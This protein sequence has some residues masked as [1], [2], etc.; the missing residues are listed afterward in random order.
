MNAGP[1]HEGHSDSRQSVVGRRTSGGCPGECG[2]AGAESALTRLAEDPR[3][4]LRI[5]GKTVLRLVEAAQPLQDAIALLR[6]KRQIGSTDAGQQQA[7]E[8]ADPVS[9]RRVNEERTV[10]SA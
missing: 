10:R 2:V 8:L 6:T 3:Q 7:N 1:V 4:P 9:A 5:A